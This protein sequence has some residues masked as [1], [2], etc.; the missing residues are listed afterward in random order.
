MVPDSSSPL[1]LH[2]QEDSANLCTVFGAEDYTAKKLENPR[3][4]CDFQEMINDHRDLFY[5]KKPGFNQVDDPNDQ[6]T[7]IKPSLNNK[8]REK[9]ILL[10][11]LDQ[12]LE[13][14]VKKTD[15]NQKR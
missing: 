15:K 10:D 1:G 7:I 4:V 11:D 12:S 9:D 5:I 6:D 2:K 3:Q 14:N 13:I 8:S